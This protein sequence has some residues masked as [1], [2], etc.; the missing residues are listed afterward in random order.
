MVLKI[1]P[2]IITSL[3]DHYIFNKSTYIYSNYIYYK[4]FLRTDKDMIKIDFFIS[5]C[6]KGENIKSLFYLGDVVSG[7]TFLTKTFKHSK[8]STFLKQLCFLQ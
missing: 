5:D 8:I 2:R 4:C 6:K 3:I 7:F 1:M